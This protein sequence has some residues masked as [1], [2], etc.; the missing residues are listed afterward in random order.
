ML[1]DAPTFSSFSVNDIEAAK[2]FYGQTLGLNTETT[3]EGMRLKLNGCDVF[4][5]TK[6]DHTP[7][8]FTVLNFTVKDIEAA[9]DEL[10]KA[11]ASFEKYDSGYTKTDERGICRNPGGVPGPQAMAW[12]KDPAGN[13]IGIMQPE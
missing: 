2:Q 10:T 1:K 7:A 8:T 13:I 5:Y 4:I 6:P 12:L 11:G 3:P 9:V